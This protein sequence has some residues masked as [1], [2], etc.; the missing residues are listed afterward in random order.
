[1]ALTK[2]DKKFWIGELQR[3]LK[4]KKSAFS[5]DVQ[6]C[7]E[8]AKTKVLEELGLT[9]DIPRL[10][11][12]QDNM[13]SDYER[14]EKSRELYENMVN[15]INKKV[16]G[17]GITAYH[18][19]GEPYTT[20]TEMSKRTPHSGYGSRVNEMDMRWLDQLAKEFL[21]GVLE[22]EG[23]VE[24]IRL[25]DESERLER[26]IMLATSNTQLKEFLDAFCERNEVEL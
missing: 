12:L 8:L 18:Y 6:R 2:T 14:Y 25:E 17:V 1:M 20:T 7:V 10:Q 22:E 23:I 9:K 3:E 16:K 13:W 5:E 21:P 19:G 24:V 15:D 4:L 26:N 11:K